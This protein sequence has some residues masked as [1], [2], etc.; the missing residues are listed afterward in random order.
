MIFR[1]FIFFVFLLSLF[2]TFSLAR[3]DSPPTTL[4]AN[5]RA[6]YRFDYRGDK[7]PIEITLDAP[8]VDAL[9][10][11]VYTPAELEAA[12]RGDALV[13]IGRGTR[14]QGHDL[15]WSGVFN[16][17]GVY[18]VAVENH[19]PAPILYHLDIRGE[20]VS[21]IAQILADAPQ[22]NSAF[23]ME[24]GTR[25]LTVNLPPGAGQAQLRISVPNAPA[26]CTHA[27]EIAPTLSHSLKLCP[28]EIYPPL[29][30]VG[31]NVAL[32]SDDARSALVT[33]SGRQFAI[34]I[35][36]ANNL[37]EGVMIQAS[38]DASDFGAWLCQYDECVFPTL[39]V[40]TTLRGG[41]LYGG[42]ILLRG[43]NST[44]H[45]VTVHGGTIGIATL[46]GRANYLIDNQLNDLNGW[47]SYNWASSGSYFVGNTINRENH[48]C[49]TPDGFKFEH[50]CETAGWT[51][52]ACT[53]NIVARNHCESSA[54][55]FYLSGERGLASN[56]NRL[57]AN[58]CAG[59]S[60]N[61]FELTFSRGNILQDN[62]ATADPDTGG[63]CNYP[64]W[65]GG[66]TVYFQNNAWQCAVS[67]DDALARA[68]NSTRVPTVALSL[69]SLNIAV[70][71][72]VPTPVVN[73]ITSA[74]TSPLP[75][76]S[77]P[78][79]APKQLYRE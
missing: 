58:Y 71:I 65:I 10:L 27:N 17:P 43:S 35:E 38:A 70:P 55:C 28:S 77:T 3:A 39:P 12:K 4:I 51:C 6:E 11:L 9:E 26:A 57:I 72:V 79:P 31:T 50:G 36:G 73:T 42:G 74:P 54:N 21:G 46:N 15:I 30:L 49:A 13:P 19:T 44:I 56:Y 8:G 32:Y 34:T 63:A 29:H 40:K 2:A 48:P 47:G 76:A 14:G 45:N 60:D 68:Q 53:S 78:A 16:A 75:P 59:A 64:F 23:S 61:C 66:S 20:S 24:N 18:Q 1:K 5:G 33:S 52:V 41:I 69:D 22:N 7:T 25:V 67:V 37:V 62:V